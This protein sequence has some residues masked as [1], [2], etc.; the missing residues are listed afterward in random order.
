MAEEGL[1][2][3]ALTWTGPGA[4]ANTIDLNFS[5]EGVNFI[6]VHTVVL[7][8][9]A[10]Q[11]SNVRDE[12]EQVMINIGAHTNSGSLV[13]PLNYTIMG[14]RLYLSATGASARISCSY[15][16]LWKTDD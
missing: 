12:R 2:F 14:S 9:L 13:I 7:F 10:A 3:G 11:A 16:L 4:A 5:T 15:Q 6:L 8:V 1:R